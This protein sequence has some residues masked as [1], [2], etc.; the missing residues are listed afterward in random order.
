MQH[1]WGDSGP[2]VKTSK[3]ANVRIS[4]ESIN[5]I[6]LNCIVDKQRLKKMW[7]GICWFGILSNG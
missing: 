6:I 7:V 1:V 2:E 4:W 5:F 3:E